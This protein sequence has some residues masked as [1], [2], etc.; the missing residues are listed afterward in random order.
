[1]TVHDVLTG[2]GYPFR[3]P[4]KLHCRTLVVFT[5]RDGNDLC[6]AVQVLLSRWTRATGCLIFFELYVGFNAQC[7]KLAKLVGRASI[8]VVGG[9]RIRPSG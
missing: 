8:V 3:F 5:Y 1:V 7:D 2:G 4:N 6:R 9:P